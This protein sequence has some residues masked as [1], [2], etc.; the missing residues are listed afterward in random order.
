MSAQT[1]P[2]RPSAPINTPDARRGNLNAHQV[3]PLRVRHLQNQQKGDM[4]GLIDPKQLNDWQ[5]MNNVHSCI[6]GHT[7]FV[8]T[9]LPLAIALMP[10]T[11]ALNRGLR[12]S[13]NAAATRLRDRVN[14]QLDLNLVELQNRFPGVDAVK[15]LSAR[16]R[17]TL[18]RHINPNPTH[19]YQVP[20]SQIPLSMQ[21][22]RSIPALNRM[23]RMKNA[24]FDE[25]IA[26]GKIP[27]GADL[28]TDDS[29]FRFG[30]REMWD[31]V[32][33]YIKTVPDSFGRMGKWISKKFTSAKKSVTGFFGN[34]KNKVT[35]WWD[36]VTGKPDPAMLGA[37]A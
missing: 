31:G 5:L 20:F 7:R 18:D 8:R 4:Y 25:L 22:R 11:P 2:Q 9:E 32:K 14:P 3:H 12:I 1:S 33:S 28:H 13:R 19:W 34:M 27:E 21:S 36:Y 17:G 26:Q 29:T 10:P 24:M 37:A 16:M 23:Q 35:R 15:D 6:T 30:P